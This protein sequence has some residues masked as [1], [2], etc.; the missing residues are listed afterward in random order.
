MRKK[1]RAN[2]LIVNYNSSQCDI[3]AQ[4]TSFTPIHNQA[5]EHGKLMLAVN[6]Q[7]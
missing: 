5:S 7:R 1:S 2:N 4:M 3:F 6:S